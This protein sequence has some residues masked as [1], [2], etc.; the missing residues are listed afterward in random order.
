MTVY[1]LCVLSVHNLHCL[2]FLAK[3]L[4]RRQDC[5]INTDKNPA[6]GEALRQ[7]KRN[8]PNVETIEHRLEADHSPTKRL[9]R[10]TV[11][12]KSMKGQCHYQGFRGDAHDPEAPGIT[13]E[14]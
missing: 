1:R 12:F 4:G 9:C 8:Y 5:L 6:Y 14:V 11:G 13:G 10:V 2:H 3:A 7:L